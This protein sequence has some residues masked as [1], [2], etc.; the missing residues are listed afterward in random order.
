MKKLVRL[1]LLEASFL[2]RSLAVTFVI[3]TAFAA[4][5]LS[6][7]SVLIDT[8]VGMVEGMDSSKKHY[9]EALGG[10]SFAVRLDDVSMN[11]AVD[12]GAAVCYA[13]AD[14]KTQN[15]EL[16]SHVGKVF[17]TDEITQL[18]G[19][20]EYRNERH[21]YLTDLRYADRLQKLVE[22]EPRRGVLLSDYV[23]RELD[24][25]RGDELRVKAVGSDDEQEYV[26]LGVYERESVSHKYGMDEVL[27]PATYF[28]VVEQADDAVCDE[29]YFG[30]ASCA[31]L[32]KLCDRLDKEGTPYVISWAMTV[33][34]ENIALVQT[35]YGSLAALLGVMLLFVLYALITTFFRERKGQMCRFE[36]LGATNAVIATVYCSIAVTLIILS[37]VLASGLSVLLSKHLLNV[38]TQMFGSVYP[39]HYRVWLPLSVAGAGSIV[40]T[41]AFALTAWRRSRLPVAQEVRYE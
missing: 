6:V 30:F 17:L 29:V 32:N 20:M 25:E 12:Y 4:A 35:L 38:C 13:A 22:F 40:A 36:L 16:I 7:T 3:L 34:R 27:L 11:R 24:V 15:V 21:G 8:P 9:F 31:R 10:E 26:V 1:I 19:D 41:A 28:Y 23:A 18:G 2:K 39:Y 5:F 33:N 14:G 37:V